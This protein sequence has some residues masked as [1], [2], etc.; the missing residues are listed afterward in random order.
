M[1]NTTKVP[2]LDLSRLETDKVAFVK[3]LGDAYREFGFC[4]F[5]NH[6]IPKETIQNVYKIFKHFFSLPEAVKL[7]YKVDKGV[8]GYTPFKVETA[9]QSSFPDLKEFWH[10][11][12]EYIPDPN[13]YEGILLPNLWPAEMPDFKASCLEMYYAMEQLGYRVL[14]GMC[15]NIGL[16]EN[17]FEN[18]CKWGNSILRALHYP[19]VNQ[20][21]Y[22]CIRAEA[23]E[24]ISLI[25]LL[26]GAMGNGLEILRPDGTWLPIVG[27]DSNAIVVNVG[28]MFQRLTNHVYPSTTHRVVNPVGDEAKVSRY[29]LPFFFDPNPD[30]LIETLPSCIS[31]N[32]PNKYPNPITA[33]DYLM[34]RLREIKLYS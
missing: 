13:I 9:K 8:R 5:S 17:Y 20:D 26:V 33:D 2:T 29:S 31:E 24:D 18:K 11:G 27:N 28:D 7:K 19:P 16:P 4:C 3:E 15:L 25:T 14:R 23:H 22:P 1:S 12:R 30:F 21:D 10:V 6:G 34:E 32:N